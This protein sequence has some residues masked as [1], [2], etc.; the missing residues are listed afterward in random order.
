MRITRLVALL[1]LV[2][3]GAPVR[4]QDVEM[5]PQS[6]RLDL[7]EQNAWA[8]TTRD[9]AALSAMLT[10]VDTQG[11][12]RMRQDSLMTVA[13]S[14]GAIRAALLAV[15]QLTNARADGERQDASMR[16]LIEAAWGL[17]DLLAQTAF[18]ASQDAIDAGTAAPTLDGPVRAARL[19]EFEDLIRTS[20]AALGIPLP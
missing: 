11:A 9:V 8:G 2:L 12:V 10:R 4:A 16:S 18:E 20:T 17:A 3:T 19:G 7:V 5:P 6:E 13:V 14:A 1:L 15:V